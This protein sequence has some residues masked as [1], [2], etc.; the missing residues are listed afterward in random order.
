MALKEPIKE[1]IIYIAEAGKCQIQ[2]KQ[3]AREWSQRL[4]S[5]LRHNEPCLIGVK[6]N[7]ERKRKYNHKMQEHKNH[8]NK[9][10]M[11]MMLQKHQFQH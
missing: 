3:E 4:A 8:Q 6:P 7:L 10:T 1:A 5:L 9:T 11:Q 2:E